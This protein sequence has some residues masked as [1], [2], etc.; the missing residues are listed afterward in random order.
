MDIFTKKVVRLSKGERDILGRASDILYELYDEVGSF[1]SFDFKLL[2]YDLE[3][4]SYHEEFVIETEE[5]G[6]VYSRLFGRPHFFLKKGI[7]K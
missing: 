5:Q 2:A 1:S 7:D 3:N 6:E 4:L